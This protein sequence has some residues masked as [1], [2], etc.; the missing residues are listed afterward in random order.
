M[1]I[2]RKNWFGPMLRPLSSRIDQAGV[3]GSSLPCSY[4]RQ[5]QYEERSALYI[6][7]LGQRMVDCKS[8]ECT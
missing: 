1:A 7:R 8:V 4:M 3:R 5:P 2:D 6:E